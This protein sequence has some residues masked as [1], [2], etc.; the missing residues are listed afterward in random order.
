MEENLELVLTFGKLTD[1]REDTAKT[2]VRIYEYM[3]LAVPFINSLN[4]FFLF[5][6]LFRIIIL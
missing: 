5:L 6:F 4:G 2:F 1:E 3:N